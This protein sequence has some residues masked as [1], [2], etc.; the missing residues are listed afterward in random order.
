MDGLLE[1]LLQLSQKFL[2][3]KNQD[4]RRYFIRT[5]TLSERLSILIGQRGV[6]KTTLLVQYLLD[7]AGGDLFSPKILYVPSDH[8]TLSET[9]LYQIAEEFE[10]NGGEFIAFD[11]IHK[12][13]SWSAELKS[14]YDSFPKLKVIASGSSALEIHKGSHDLSRRSIIYRIPGLSFREYLEM[15]LKIQLPTF[16]FDDL[17]ENHQKQCH[18]IMSMLEKNQAGKILPHFRKYLSFGYYPYYFELNDDAKFEITVEQNV[19]TTIEADLTSIYPNLS[20]IT[21]KKIRHLLTFI[22]QNAPYTP[23]WLNLKKLL[24]IG[25]ERT[26]KTYFTLL[27]DAELLISLYKSS[28][29]LDSLDNPAKIYLQNTNLCYVIAKG[30]ENIGTI[31]ETFLL[32]MF[33]RTHHVTLPLNG[34]FLIDKTILLEVGGANKSAKQIRDH[35]RPFVVQDN[36]EIGIGNKIPLWLFGFMY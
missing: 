25:D 12:V 27:E 11:E 18:E 6:G 19:H 1:K 24:E 33:Y 31:R 15:A 9:S 7:H 20:G 3:A 8:L 5:T 10:K 21:I 23:N 2:M 28:E 36:I 16:A 29:K 22:A 17:L 14:I 13:T 26:L 32:N 30:Y 35:Q 4:Y 34:D